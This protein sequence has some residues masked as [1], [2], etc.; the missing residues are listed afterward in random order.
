MADESLKNLI[1]RVDELDIAD[2][3]NGSQQPQTL[4]AAVDELDQT[5]D[6]LLQQATNIKTLLFSN[7]DLA[8]GDTATVSRVYRQS[9]NIGRLA[10]WLN[11]A[12]VESIVTHITSLDDRRYGDTSKLLKHFDDS[13]KMIAR[14]FLSQ[15]KGN[16]TDTLWRIVEDCCIQA[17]PSGKLDPE[18]YFSEDI[19]AR[20]QLND[21]SKKEA[22]EDWT[23]FW[24]QCLNRCPCGPTLFIPPKHCH[25]FQPPPPLA[26]DPP[27][28]LFR[29]YDSGSLGS[30][31]EE[32][33][34]SRG[35][36]NFGSV[37][38]KQDLLTMDRQD[39]STMLHRHLNGPYRSI[40]ADNL[41]SWSS[42]LLSVIQ[43]A[44]Y[45]CWKYA[46][47]DSS[48]V[49]IC[50]V[51]TTEFPKGQ[52]ASGKWLRGRYT[53]TKLDEKE[54][55]FLEMRSNNPDYDNGEYLSQGI[56]NVRD[57]S[58]TTS[59]LSLQSAGLGLLYRGLDV[60]TEPNDMVRTKWTIYVRHLRSQ[61]TT[62]CETSELEID[63]ARNIA[64]QCFG[65]FEE[66]DISLLLLALRSRTPSDEGEFQTTRIL[67]PKPAD[68][69]VPIPT[70]ER[71]YEEEPEEVQRY[72]DLQLRK[73]TKA[74]KSAA[75]LDQLF[76]LKPDDYSF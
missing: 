13:I 43:Y 69:S 28:Y 68:S 6:H 41:V 12:V 5:V 32:I 11:D 35:H 74:L 3:S 72:V 24:A 22:K 42:S 73:R 14:R 51:D 55:S 44:N 27:R 71:L 4:I 61:W 50:A 46:G 45:R 47:Q 39:A 48:N 20:T 8:N 57:R 53:S 76:V 33:F 36:E 56:L 65:L 34:T 70:Q 64:R 63:I 17:V 15:G 52:F 59:L 21:D 30:N 38:S 62:S 1:S 19:E 67:H 29:A 31:G 26:D 10:L 2:S 18:D 60:L 7:G 49:F 58:C 37:H 66:M 16:D 40:E 75:Y 54:R 23:R 25:P 9:Y